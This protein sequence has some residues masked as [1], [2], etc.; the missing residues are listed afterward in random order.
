M[1]VSV[2]TLG[3]KVNQYES[4]AMLGQLLK[5]GFQ[6][7]PEGEAADVVLLNSCT[8]TSASDQKVRQTLHRARRTHPDAVIVLTGC[9]PQAFPEE[10]EGLRE[11]DVVL[12]NRN[13]ASLLPHILTYLSTHQ[14]IVDIQPHETGDAFE[15]MAV[16]EFHDR[17]RAFLKIQDGCNRFCSYCIIPYARGRVRSKPLEQVRED[18][19]A[20]AG[21]GYREVVLTGINL[22][23]YGQE[24][25][26]HLC[27][28]VETAASVPGIERVR[29]GSLEPELLPEAVIARLAKQDKLCPQFH[30]SL[31]SGCDAT[32]RR[33]NRHYNT[34]EYRAIVENLR[35]AFPNAAITTDIMVGFPGETDGEFAENLAF[36]KEIGFAKA[37]VFAYSR[38]PGTPA[39]NAPD[40]VPNAV[41]EQR[42]RAMT[43]ATQDT[44]R[45][46]YQSQLG[47]VQ[48]VLLEQERTPGVWEGYTPNYTPVLVAASGV[49][50]GQ[51]VPVRLERLE[52]LHCA[53]SLAT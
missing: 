53:G 44:Q 27:D 17:T 4:Q 1:K 10:A 37:H 7:C 12:G 47:S 33:M 36:A 11:A 48:P 21:H 8:V 3:C 26:L 18:V 19:Q 32:L 5:G 52:K 28:A 51:I 38:R 49:Q 34:A 46:F 2:I 50:G 14:R 39:A 43:Q 13:R 6:T 35:A 25:N 40:Q 24:Q 9:M 41:K 20:L 22:S 16:G 23:S 31:Q 29:L 15:T 42:S 30:L 45:A